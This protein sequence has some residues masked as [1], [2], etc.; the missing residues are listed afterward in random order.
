MS[1]IPHVVARANR[2]V[3][4]P[5]MSRVAG[6]LPLFG[7]LT[8]VGRRSGRVYTIPV[9]VF[10]DGERGYRIA[11]TYGRD[12]QWVR[13]VLAAGGCTLLTRGRVV[14]L[15][16]PRVIHDAARSWAP[17]PVR[18]ILGLIRAPDILLLHEP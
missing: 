16:E 9:N 3:L 18:Q 7:L 14:E 12:A 8:H 11:L 1:P 13:N 17:V 2:H 10:R 6:H 15:V 4:N 5:L